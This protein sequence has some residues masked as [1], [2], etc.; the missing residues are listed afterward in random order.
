MTLFV[1]YWEEGKSKVFLSYNI[2]LLCVKDINPYTHRLAFT[3]RKTAS[4]QPPKGGMIKGRLCWHILLNREDFYKVFYLYK[5]GSMWCSHIHQDNRVNGQ[6][7]SGLH[8][9]VNRNVMMQLCFPK[10]LLRLNMAAHGCSLS[11]WDIE[12]GGWFESGWSR[13]V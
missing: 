13:P 8:F 12:V 3:Y 1:I 9:T 2:K 4:S 11:T 5:H 7:P 10:Q 6:S